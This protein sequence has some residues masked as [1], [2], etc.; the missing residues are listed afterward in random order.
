MIHSKGPALHTNG[1]I[2]AVI[3]SAVALTTCL[4]GFSAAFAQNSS[5]SG[6]RW[7]S[8]FPGQLGIVTGSQI[9]EGQAVRWVEV[10]VT[11][12][13]RLHSMGLFG[14]QKGD[15]VKMLCIESDVWRIKHY[16]TGLAIT[17]STRPF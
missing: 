12:P 13:D 15:R 11:D 5:D 3:A 1:K 14:V 16:A 8:A 7:Q 10:R 6:C 2:L 4:A 17:F 9:A